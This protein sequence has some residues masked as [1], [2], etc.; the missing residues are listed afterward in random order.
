LNI[1][2]DADISKLYGEPVTWQCYEDVVNAIAD[3]DPVKSHHLTSD[4]LE[5]FT[6]D[7]I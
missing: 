7:G 6:N 5:R 3:D 2:T 1:F 4:D